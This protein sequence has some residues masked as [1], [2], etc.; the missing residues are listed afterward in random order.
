MTELKVIG[1]A[2][3]SEYLKIS[4]CLTRLMCVNAYADAYLVYVY[5]LCYSKEYNKNFNQKELCKKLG[6]SEVRMRNAF[7]DLKRIGLVTQRRRG[8]DWIYEV[9]RISCQQDARSL[10][11]KR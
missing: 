7:K 1:K 3:D 2:P 8:K 11:W 6:F 10:N 4:N 9:K 5:I